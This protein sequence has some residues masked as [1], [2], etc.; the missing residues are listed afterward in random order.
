MPGSS[1][2]LCPLCGQRGRLLRPSTDVVVNVLYRCTSCGA[3]WLRDMREP[4]AP[5]RILVR[6][7]D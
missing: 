4:N 5:P 6:P 1:A 7:L 2:R 3:V